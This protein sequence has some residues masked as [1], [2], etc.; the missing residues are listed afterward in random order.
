MKDLV[1]KELEEWVRVFDT[2]RFLMPV[3]TARNRTSG[4]PSPQAAESWPPPLPLGSM[5]LHYCLLDSAAAVPVYLQQTNNSV[6]TCFPLAT[7]HSIVLLTGASLPGKN[8][9]LP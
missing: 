2:I 8:N 3:N 7:E 4:V 6:N 5:V 9:L 1:S